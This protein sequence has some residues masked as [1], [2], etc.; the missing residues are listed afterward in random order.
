[1]CF[2]LILDNHFGFPATFPEPSWKEVAD[3]ISPHQQHVAAR[4]NDLLGTLA[5]TCRARRM[6]NFQTRHDFIATMK[7]GSVRK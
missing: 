2:Y 4:K 6:L 3:L 7:A 5:D 1:V